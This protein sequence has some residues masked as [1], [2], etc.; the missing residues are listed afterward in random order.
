MAI[1]KSASISS[2][3]HPR[4]DLE[5]PCFSTEFTHSPS[6]IDMSL[7]PESSL[8]LFPSCS[9]ASSESSGT[10]VFSDISSQSESSCSS[11]YGEVTPHKAGGNPLC[12]S[13]SPTPVEDD[14]SLDVDQL[15][16]RLFMQDAL[17]GKQNL[18]NWDGLAEALRVYF[19]NSWHKDQYT[20]KEC[21]QEKEFLFWNAVGNEKWRPKR[22]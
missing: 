7:Q 15:A 19:A 20:L 12:L 18:P 17:S 14:S 21:E 10:S 8:A 6:K 3:L 4:Q 2:S 11:V 1:Q 5:G 9:S 22:G 13:E 16:L